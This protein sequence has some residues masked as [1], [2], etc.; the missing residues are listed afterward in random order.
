VEDEDSAKEYLHGW[1]NSYEAGKDSL[2]P[3]LVEMEDHE[4]SK[5]GPR[6]LAKK[7]VDRVDSVKSRWSDTG[8]L[9]LHHRGI[10][11][12]LREGGSALRPISVQNVLEHIRMTTSSGLPLLVKKRD[13]LDLTVRHLPAFLSRYDP[14][15][16]FTRT[17][18]LLKTRDTLGAPLAEVIVEQTHFRPILDLRRKFYWRSALRGPQYVEAEVTQLMRAARDLDPAWLVS[19]DF[20]G[21]DASCQPRL[22]EPAL[23]SMLGL[24]PESEERER[25]IERFINIPLVTP[26]GVFS[27]PHGVPSGS[28]FT[29]EVNSQVQYLASLDY[30]ELESRL[31]QRARTAH[32]LNVQGDDGVYVV[33]NPDELKATFERY[34]LTVNDDK[35]R[36][37]KD[38]FVYLQCLYHPDIVT[39]EGNYG[40]V[41]PTYRALNRIVHPERW[42]NLEQEAIT[43]EDYFALRA[44]AIM[45]NCKR[46]PLRYAFWDY[47][48][49][50]DKNSL[51]FDIQSIPEYIA[52]LDAK[53]GTG[54]AN[55]FGDNTLGLA[56]F[57]C[58]RYLRAKR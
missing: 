44:L 3:P 21:Y 12:W 18:E 56:N 15:V 8:G 53:K 35:S 52:L 28:S 20:S 1:D 4:R 16:L 30:F 6:S 31:G 2:P 9:T 33:S 37:E 45:E 26:D 54:I 34:G 29:L 41:Y 14:A 39:P 57:E 40:A 58:V 22:T 19:I 27:G 11:D 10:K 7:W 49:S 55:Q 47:V 5:F 43:G 13:A 38:F 23:R 48:A 51:K 36:V 50:K 46:H 17:Q 24:F 32:L 42:V 25:I